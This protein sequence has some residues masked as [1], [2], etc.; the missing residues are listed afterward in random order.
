MRFAILFI[1]LV[2]LSSD[3]PRTVI[4][5]GCV[6]GSMV[7]ATEVDKS[8][9]YVDQFFLHGSKELMKT[10][11]KDNNGKEI[12]VTGILKDPDGVMGDGTT[13]KVGERM[14]VYTQGRTRK[15]TPDPHATTPSITVQTFRTVNDIC[16]P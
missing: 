4:V 11:T 7:R 2:S 16:R 13:V 12:E 1:A 9:T 15:T 8:G 6:S 3:K 10:I 14:T 5:K